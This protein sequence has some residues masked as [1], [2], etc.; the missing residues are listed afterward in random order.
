MLDVNSP[1]EILPSSEERLAVHLC[2]LE[3]LIY[4]QRQLDDEVLRCSVV[5]EG[6]SKR[7]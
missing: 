7:W 5:A 4:G 3:E 1:A 2:R 6:Q